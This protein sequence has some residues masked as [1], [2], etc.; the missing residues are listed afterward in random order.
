MKKKD[1]RPALDAL[2][3]VKLQKIEDKKLRKTIVSN[4]V[5]LVVA[6]NAFE[7]KRKAMEEAH[8]G[9][10]EKQRE[11]VAKLQQELQAETDRNKQKELLRQINENEELF[12]A[13]KEFNKDFEALGNEEVEVKGI[14]Q[15]EFIEEIQKQ[16]FDLGII[17]ALYPM[18]K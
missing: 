16:D 12:A 3:P 7:E 11:E 10:Y 8:L 1:I 18:F 14:P 13:V 9:A 5:T 17:E 2:K 15:D 6:W 4:Y